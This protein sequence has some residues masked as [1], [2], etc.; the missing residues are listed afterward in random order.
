[1]ILSVSRAEIE[2]RL[3]LLAREVE[4]RDQAVA[5]GVRIARAADQLDDRVQVVERDQQSL[6]DVGAGLGAAQLV[7]GAPDDHLALV[8]HVVADQRL[9]PERARHA[10]H[11]RDHVH[12]ERRLHRRVLVELVEH[13]ARVDVALELDHHADAALVR[14]VA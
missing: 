10:V 7:L 13:H 3:R 9:E 11:E 1:L 12:A 8:V 2:D 4:A 14:L 5:R 6:E